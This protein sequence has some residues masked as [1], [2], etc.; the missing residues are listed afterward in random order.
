MPTEPI[1]EDEAV[2]AVQASLRAAAQ[3]AAPAHPAEDDAAPRPDNAAP[4]PRPRGWWKWLVAVPLGAALSTA[5][6]G[7]WAPRLAPVLAPVMAPVLAPA[8][9]LLSVERLPY[10]GPAVAG[11]LAG[12]LPAPAP[13]LS[14]TMVAQVSPLP[15][16][17]RLLD[18]TGL[19][20]NPG[21]AGVVMPAIAARLVQDGRTLRRWTIPP[22]V[23]SIAPRGS[24]VFASSITDVPPGTV[25]VQL[26]IV[27]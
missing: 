13:P 24:T 5:A 19:V 8:S 7:L 12:L 9:G 14:V 2:A 18:V 17:G 6:A 23:A 4:V 10:V 1:D 15:G 27:Q 22:P 11:A 21:A 26:R 20:H 3:P 25:T 16:G